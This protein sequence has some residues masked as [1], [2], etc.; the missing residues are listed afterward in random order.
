MGEQTDEQAEESS[1]THFLVES[2]PVY[3]RRI[4]G[5]DPEAKTAIDLKKVTPKAGKPRYR[6]E[7]GEFFDSHSNAINHLRE[8]YLDD[9]GSVLTASGN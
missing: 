9:S 5:I 4:I 2:I 7:C 3:H 6:C 1:A 8:A